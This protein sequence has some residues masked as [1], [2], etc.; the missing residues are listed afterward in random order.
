M[1]S[2]PFKLTF[3]YIMKLVEMM[4]MYFSL[5]ILFLYGEMLMSESWSQLS[6]DNTASNYYFS[7]NKESL[8]DD[9]Y[10]GTPCTQHH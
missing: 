10:R 3:N 1:K 8:V 6:L 2:N 7:L 9:L 4:K 5:Q